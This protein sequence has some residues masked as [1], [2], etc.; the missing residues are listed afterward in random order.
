MKKMSGDSKESGVEDAVE[1]EEEEGKTKGSPEMAKS[2]PE[3]S[4]PGQ[5]VT[6][7]LLILQRMLFILKY[8]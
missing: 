3:L 7:V 2:K 5:S 4:S 1:E 8:L 6:A